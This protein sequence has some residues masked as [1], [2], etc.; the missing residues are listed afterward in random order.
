MSLLS[1]LRR[2]RLKL[3]ELKRRP[4]GAGRLAGFVL[5]AS[6]ELILMH[7]VDFDTFTLNG[8]TAIRCSDIA[9]FRSFG[10]HEYW[11]RRAVEHFGL[12]PV[13]VLGLPVGSFGEL[14][15]SKELAGR[16]VSVH[17]ER[18]AANVFFIGPVT[19][20]AGGRLT[21]EDLDRNAKWS[22][23]RRIRLA[24]VTRVDFAD[25]YLRALEATAPKRRAALRKT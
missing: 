6:P 13:P 2:H 9:A 12:V 17:R 16:L 3:F 21:M 15:A 20:V 18:M 19:S 7:R 25:G 24:D 8:Y 10:R 11:Q 14:L 22:G 1:L 23:P 5:D 4:A